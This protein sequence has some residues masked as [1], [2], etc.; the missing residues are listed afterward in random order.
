VEEQVIFLHN[1][2]VDLALG[3]V[4]ACRGEG[5]ILS[6]GVVDH[7]GDAFNQALKHIRDARKGSQ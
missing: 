6:D 2:A 4:E 5:L 1:L 3:A 7:L